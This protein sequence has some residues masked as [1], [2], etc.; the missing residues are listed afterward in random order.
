MVYSNV[1]KIRRLIK[2]QGSSLTDTDIMTSLERSHRRVKHISNGGSF[3]EKK[4][5]YQKAPA[6]DIRVEVN[7]A[8]MLELRTV[9]IRTRHKKGRVITED[10]E[11]I[12]EYGFLIP[13]ETISE[14]TSLSSDTETIFLVTYL[15]ETATHRDLEE[16][17][18]QRDLITRMDI[19]LGNTDS[20]TRV[21]Q[22]NEDIMRLEKTINKY[23]GGTGWTGSLR[24]GRHRHNGYYG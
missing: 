11:S 21:E 18:T 16:A 19:D 8:T 1:K 10:V 7:H 23:S 4:T 22:L 13:K 3:R 6:E 17:L 2:K 14:Y 9:S 20:S 12:D 5:Y 24:E 15:Y